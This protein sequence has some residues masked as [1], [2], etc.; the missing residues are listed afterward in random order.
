[1]TRGLTSQQKAQ[2]GTPQYMI[3]YCVKLEASVDLCVWQG[4]GPLVDG[5][6]T[7]IGTGGLLQLAPV[8]QNLDLGES[9]YEI[10]LSGFDSDILSIVQTE[11]HEGLP[12]TI[13]AVIFDKDLNQISD[14]LTVKRGTLSHIMSNSS[15]ETTTIIL[16]MAGIN[17][18][19]SKTDALIHTD[20]DQKTNYPGDT[21]FEAMATDSSR[22]II[23]EFN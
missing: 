5:D 1:M 14:L 8:E 9:E 18:R 20:T 2:L 11:D 12:V 15:A 17:N 7:Y 10:T 19:L 13:K 23:W 3:M 16:S 6:D 22:E 4:V 21:I